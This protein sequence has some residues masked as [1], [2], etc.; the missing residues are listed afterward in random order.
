MRF[1]V[2]VSSMSL[3]GCVVYMYTE[4]HK[5]IGEKYSEVHDNNMT[6]NEQVR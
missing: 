2:S 4:P 3:Y 1:A 6:W 5:Y